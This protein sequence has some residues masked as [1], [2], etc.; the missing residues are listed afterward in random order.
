MKNESIIVVGILMAIFGAFMIVGNMP[1]TV[2][3][4]EGNLTVEGNLNVTGTGEF[5][6]DVDMNENYILNSDYNHWMH[7][8]LEKGA[9]DVVLNIINSTM[10]EQ[11]RYYHR[12]IFAVDIAPGGADIVNCSISNG[13]STMTVALTG[14]QTTDYTTTNAFALDVSDESLV[15]YYSQ[16][17]GGSATK[18]FVAIK[19]HFKENE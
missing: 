16:T 7:F 2:E 11:D 12:F 6:G 17:A 18:G 19:Y 13:V 8:S 15:L 1:V 4:F 10:L 9:T 5:G 3:D 14:D